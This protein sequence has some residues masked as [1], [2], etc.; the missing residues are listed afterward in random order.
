MQGLHMPIDGA[1]DLLEQEF[2]D[3]AMIFCQYVSDTLERLQSTLFVVCC[4]SG[5]LINW[6]KSSGFVI[7]VDDVC[8]WGEHQGFTWVALGLTCRYLGFYVGL[9]GLVVNQVLLATTWFTT[10]CW[11]LYPRALSRVRRLVRNF[12]WG[13][14]NGI[15]DSR[16]RVCWRT[17]ILLRQEVGLG[18]IDPEMQKDIEELVELT[19][20]SMGRLVCRSVGNTD[21]ALD[22]YNE[23]VEILSKLPEKDSE[24]I[25]ALSVSLNKM[26]DL[27]YYADDLQAA[28]AYYARSLDVRRSALQEYTVLS[29]QVL[30]LAV[31]LA[32]VADVDRALGNDG[33]ASEGFQ[34]AIKMLENLSGKSRENTSL[35]RRRLSILEFLHGQT[36]K[37]A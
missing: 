15:Q 4:A 19:E 34:E 10:S 17:V 7:G 24:V 29:S 6:H 21:S 30:D 11:T 14:S 18:I 23:S 33:P 2:V 9:E 36:N 8:R 25:H 3:D 35:E 32:K 13:G 5:S 20:D 12:L 22:H 28:R 26:G 1:H 27:K 37:D 31:S 16:L